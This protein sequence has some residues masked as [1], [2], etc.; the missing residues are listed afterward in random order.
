M[1]YQ[2]MWLPQEGYGLEHLTLHQQ[3]QEITAN[4]V[5]LGDRDGA[6]F[7][8]WYQITLDQNWRVRRC[9]LRLLENETREI[10]LL[11]D[12]QG[13]W[14]D[15][16]GTPLPSLNGCKDIDISAT[17]FTNTLPIRRLTLHTGQA[18]EL[19]V[20]YFSIPDLEIGTLQQRYTC[21]ENRVDGGLYRYESLTSGF[22]R[23]LTVDAE[24][25]VI[26]YPDLWKRV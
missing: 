26:D 20:V 19:T 16:A 17:P 3:E 8:L 23:D 14:S 9:R 5:V 12:G 24:G 6:L 7:R 1:D 18:V 2:Y 11:A 10:A 21:L 13:N 4:S 22:T 25:L 15:E